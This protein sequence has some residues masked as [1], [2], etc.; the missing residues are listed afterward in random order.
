[1]HKSINQSCK[2]TQANFNI[3]SK[4]HSFYFILP[5]FVVLMLGCSLWFISPYRVKQ[6]TLW[7]L[8]IAAKISLFYIP[9]LHFGIMASL[10]LN[11][12]IWNLYTRQGTIK[13]RPSSISHFSYFFLSGVMPLELQKNREHLC[14]M[15]TFFHF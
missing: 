15:D 6:K 1:M 13:G 14:P 10:S 4:P 3:C 7:K 12:I 11:K 8:I 5:S 9:H 2:T